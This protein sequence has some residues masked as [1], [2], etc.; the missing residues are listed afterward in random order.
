[1]YTAILRHV[2]VGKQGS[3]HTQECLGGGATLPYPP[4]VGTRLKARFGVRDEHVHVGFCTAMLAWGGV[5][6]VH[7]HMSACMEAVYRHL[8]EW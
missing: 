5:D 2:C 3:F 6:L 1:M 8:L 7:V 4:P